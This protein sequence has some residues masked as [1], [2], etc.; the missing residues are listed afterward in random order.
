MRDS[1]KGL[2]ACGMVLFFSFNALAQSDLE[3]LLGASVDDK[4]ITFQVQSRGCTNKDDFKFSVKEVLEEIGPMLPAYE[5][6]YY[7]TVQRVT[8]DKCE[9]FVPYGTRVFVSFDELGI[10]FGKFHISNPMGGDKIVNHSN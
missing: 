4:G 10:H 9:A 7:I 5:Y 2:A 1:M 3:Q 6:H 8:E